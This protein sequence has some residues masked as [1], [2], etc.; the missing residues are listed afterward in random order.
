MCLK[1]KYPAHITILRGN[2]ETRQISTVYGYYDE[3][4]RKYGN[5]NAW[6]YSMEV[7]DCLGLGAVVEGK[8]FCV[9]GGLSPDIKMLD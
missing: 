4:L 3:N 5:T 7:F 9:H 1:L 6:K 2:H 8:I